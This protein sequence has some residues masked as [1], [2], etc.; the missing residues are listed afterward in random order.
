[1]GRSPCSSRSGRLDR[2]SLRHTVGGTGAA[3]QPDRARSE[4]HTPE[5]QSLMRISYPVFCSPTST[6]PPAHSHTHPYT[7]STSAHTYSPTHHAPT[8][9]PSSPPPTDQPPH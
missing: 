8:P 1:M 5:L 3:R 9:A 7:H 4:E 6:A 2:L